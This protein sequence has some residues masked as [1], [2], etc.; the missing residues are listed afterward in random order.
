MLL[1]WKLGVFAVARPC[2]SAGIARGAQQG[3]AGAPSSALV[4]QGLGP[5]RGS[6]YPGDKLG[7]LPG[8]LLS[9][10]SMAGVWLRLG[11]GTGQPRSTQ[12]RPAPRHDPC[13]QGCLVLWGSRTKIP[14]FLAFPFTSCLQLCMEVAYYYNKSP[15]PLLKRTSYPCRSRRITEIAI[16]E[17]LKKE[18]ISCTDKAAAEQRCHCLVL[19]L[20]H[21]L[22]AR[23]R[24]QMRSVQRFA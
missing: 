23:E 4:L 7:A 12:Q 10:R 2:S 13:G 15:K 11:D 1:G 22:S 8:A 17:D 20:S 9:S 3:S 6:T 14:I 5:H 21:L 18:T 16:T 19:C 24:G